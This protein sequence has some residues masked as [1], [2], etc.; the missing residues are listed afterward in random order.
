MMEAIY[1]A[2]VLVATLLGLYTAL[3]AVKAS[4]KQEV[5]IK[6]EEIRKDF[7]LSEVEELKKYAALFGLDNESISCNTKLLE[8]GR[9]VE[10][11]LGEQKVTEMVELIGTTLTYSTS[12]RSL[13]DVSHL[14]TNLVRNGRLIRV[15]TVI[16]F[17]KNAMGGDRNEDENSIMG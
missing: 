1:A 11:E 15:H 3:T 8:M 10:H 16:Q 13:K 9:K 4:I 14:V 17:V 7:S 12:S 5:L 6:K 2:I